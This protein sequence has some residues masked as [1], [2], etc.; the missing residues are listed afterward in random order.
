MPFADGTFDVAVCFHVFEHIPDDLAA[1][2]DLAR[3]LSPSGIAFVQVP[4]RSGSP[5]DEDP[6]VGPEERLRRFGQA[7]HVRWYG[8]DFESRLE[9]SGLRS[10]RVVPKDLVPDEIVGVIGV[11]VRSPIWVVTRTDSAD[12]PAARMPALP[13]G[14]LAASVVAGWAWSE[15]RRTARDGH[16]EAEAGDLMRRLAV[17][18]E[19]ARKW[20]AAYHSIRNRWPV[21]VAA[22]V[23]DTVRRRG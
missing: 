4:W 13:S 2:R 18:E 10:H 22:V 1:M 5:T 14:S 7:D 8:S 16:H 15:R 20:E 21:R 3:V 23:R 17:A 9:A 12:G 19:A 6:S 11:G